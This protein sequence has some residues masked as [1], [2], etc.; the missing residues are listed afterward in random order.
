MI[1]LGA[2]RSGRDVDRYCKNMSLESG[3]VVGVAANGATTTFGAD[4]VLLTNRSLGLS[5]AESAAKG[6]VDV[7]SLLSSGVTDFRISGTVLMPLSTL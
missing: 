2:F 4:N 7:A 1:E 6:G 5:I 3:N